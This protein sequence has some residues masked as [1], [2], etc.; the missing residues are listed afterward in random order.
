[1]KD[2][3]WNERHQLTGCPTPSIKAHGKPSSHQQW[4]IIS[5]AR[6]HV[7][8]LTPSVLLLSDWLCQIKPLLSHLPV[9]ITTIPMLYR[10]GPVVQVVEYCAVKI[11]ILLHGGAI[12]HGRCICHLR[13][14]PFQP[15]VHNWSIKSCGMCCPVCGNSVL[16]CWLNKTIKKRFSSWIWHMLPT[17]RK[18]TTN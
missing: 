14:F 8:R 12:L 7:I 5:Q 15:V 4:P 10:V 1:M 9:I 3:Q 6:T 16:R 17:R 2:M 11:A 13:Y 18:E